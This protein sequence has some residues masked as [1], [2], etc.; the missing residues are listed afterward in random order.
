MKTE[1]EQLARRALAAWYRA[2]CGGEHD[3]LALTPPVSGVAAEHAG[4]RYAMVM[5]GF[6]VPLAVYRVRN[7]GVLKRL[8]QW[9]RALDAALPDPGGDGM[10][11]AVA[12]LA[13]QFRDESEETMTILIEEGR[14]CIDHVVRMLVQLTAGA[15]RRSVGPGVPAEELAKMASAHVV[16]LAAEQD[17]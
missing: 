16:R 15:I 8:R 11:I 1:N 12:L 13:A 10:R 4:K 5:N 7:D 9:P 2:D 17:G 3:P 14:P 6:R